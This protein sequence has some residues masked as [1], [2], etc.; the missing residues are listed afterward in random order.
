FV[1][2]ALAEAVASPNH[3][4]PAS[5]GD[6]VGAKFFLGSTRH[7][8]EVSTTVAGNVDTVSAASMQVFAGHPCLL[9]PG[10]VAEIAS[11]GRVLVLNVPG[12][13]WSVTT[14]PPFVEKASMIGLR[15]LY[16]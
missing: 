8:I 7:S 3:I 11:A 15:Q 5:R 10:E 6:L 16:V 9:Q 4:L 14:N 1:Q 2:I 13:D 12:Y